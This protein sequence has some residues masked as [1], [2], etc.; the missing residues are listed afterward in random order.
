MLT[1][2]SYNLLP[3]PVRVEWCTAT[4]GFY[5]RTSVH[6]DQQKL[7]NLNLEDLQRVKTEMQLLGGSNLDFHMMPPHKK[8]DF[9]MEVDALIESKSVHA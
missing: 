9:P 6:Q 5:L 4:E 3:H 7:S 2:A 8:T 1:S